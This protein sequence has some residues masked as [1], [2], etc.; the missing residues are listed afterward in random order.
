MGG[1]INVC[2][3]G[4]SGVPY[5]CSVPRGVPAATPFV[6]A[7]RALHGADS[8]LPQ[9]AL[10]FKD[11]STASLPP[12]LPIGALYDVLAPS[13]PSA[14]PF[15]LRVEVRGVGASEA[16]DAAAFAA[17]LRAAAGILSGARAG[18]EG[19]LSAAFSPARCL[20]A[21][22]DALGGERGAPRALPPAGDGAPVPL[23]VL[24]R[25]GGGGGA[26]AVVALQE[27]AGPDAPL[28]AALRAALAAGA[29]YC[30]GACGVVL[31]SAGEDA[32]A[33]THEALLHG[34]PIHEG[35]GGLLGEPLARVANAFRGP[36]GFLT[37]S[38][39]RAPGFGRELL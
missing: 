22:E 1:W 16:P 9:P 36:D 3:S 11:G 14:D 6:S 15:L 32:R 4:L 27:A 7:Y 34:V 31:P 25:E 24:L 26:D 29:A 21:F 28:L 18:G 39:R 5:V 19:A 13:P 17:S 8:P 12:A 2:L 35:G 33:C 30:R 38:L 23:R 37:I 20:A 10:F